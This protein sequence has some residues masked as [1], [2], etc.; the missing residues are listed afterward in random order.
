MGGGASGASGGLLHPYSPKAKVLWRGGECWKECLKLLR[1]AEGAVQAKGLSLDASS[2][3]F[4]EPIV[5]RRGILRP[6][7][8]EK[9]AEILKENAQKCLQSCTLEVLDG[10]AAHCLVPNLHVPFNS[11]I[12]MPQAMNIH[13]KKYLQALFLA[14]LN[15]TE[16]TTA[17]DCEEREMKLYRLSVSSLQELAGK[18][19]AVIVCL[20][21]K[22]NMLLELKGKLPLRTCRGVIAQLQLPNLDISGE[23]PNDSPSILS[24]AWLAFQG[25]Q[26]V[27]MGSTW[28]WKS[29]NYSS[30][31]TSEELSKAF[32]E[33][34]PKASTVYPAIKRWELAGARAGLR[35]MPPLTPLG[36]LP[37]LGCV[38]D[39]VEGRLGCNYW[40][41][42]GL[43]ARGL[44]YHGL[45]GKLMAHAV[46]SSDETVLPS[47]LTSWKHTKQIGRAHV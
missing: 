12:Y 32:E 37:L 6:A 31:V 26:S 14:C 22:S 2:F 35:A 9:N 11:A 28:D 17:S 38:N 7:T 24:D 4:D 8:T 43:G 16:G 18:Y 5:L 21:A 46:I 45:L 23:Y 36:S 15:L 20:G 3:N 29:R 13:P 1:V 27:L 19:D 41:V 30:E 33:L 44:L 10:N 25:P 40:L 42:G 39:L 47:E 34:L